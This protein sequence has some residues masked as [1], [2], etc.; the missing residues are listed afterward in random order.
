MKMEVKADCISA[1]DTINSLLLENQALTSEDYRHGLYSFL[2]VTSLVTVI[3]IPG[4]C[5]A[6]L[7]P[8]A[9]LNSSSSDS[10]LRML[11]SILVMLP[12]ETL[13]LLPFEDLNVD[14]L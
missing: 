1:C 9:C 4:L 3:P 7:S 13:L 5:D 8:A 12:L 2:T 10:V 11:C 6:R 14:S